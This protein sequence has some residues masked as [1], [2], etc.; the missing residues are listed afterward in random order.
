MYPTYFQVEIELQ[1]IAANAVPGERKTNGSFRLAIIERCQK[2]F[3]GDKSSEIKEIEKEIET[4]EEEKDEAKKTSL[5]AR[6]DLLKAKE[7]R[8]FLGIILSVI[9]SLLS[10][11]KTRTSPDF[12]FI[13]QLYRH[14]LLI[15]KIIEWCVVELVKRYG[16]HVSGVATS[17]ASANQH[18]IFSL[19]ERKRRDLHRVRRK[20]VARCRPDLRETEANQGSIRGALP[21]RRR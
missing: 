5:Q 12:R 6:I 2:T 11:S 14:D 19:S 9:R 15:D 16:E 18:P 21:C 3:E 10:A 20:D 4:A 17:T 8:R 13:S 7:K 1:Q